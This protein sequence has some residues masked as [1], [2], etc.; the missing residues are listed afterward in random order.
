MAEDLQ[1]LDLPRVAADNP[2]LADA[3]DYCGSRP[4]HIRQL[5]DASDKGDL[6]AVKLLFETEWPERPNRSESEQ[7]IGALHGAVQH[8]CRLSFVSRRPC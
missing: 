5:E 6:V 3:V 4:T 2:I 1:I 7:L 8:A